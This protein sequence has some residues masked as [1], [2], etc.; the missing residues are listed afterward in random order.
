MFFNSISFYNYVQIEN[1]SL[2]EQ[3][4]SML[5]LPLFVN[6]SFS[7]KEKKKILQT[8][9]LIFQF[10]LAR[11]KIL[12]TKK[13][14]KT[15]SFNVFINPGFVSLFK[16]LRIAHLTRNSTKNK[17]VG[18]KIKNN[19]T[20]YIIFKDFVT[21]QSFKIKTY[22]FH[23]WRNQFVIVFPTNQHLKNS[24]FSIYNKINFFITYF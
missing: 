12:S 14:N 13:I 17:L 1:S 21:L 3:K 22:D 4:F 5:S 24:E 19:G 15:T 23:D 9:D 11:P 18:F 2:H 20:I 7:I 6:F 8:S 10:F 16:A